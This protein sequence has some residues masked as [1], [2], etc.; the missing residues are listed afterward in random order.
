MSN[1]EVSAALPLL[2]RLAPRQHA[3]EALDRLLEGEH[4]VDGLKH[5][6]LYP[7]V[8]I[9]ISDGPDHHDI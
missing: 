2:V 5:D 1:V 4:S 7:M 8:L 3:E 9:M 6:I